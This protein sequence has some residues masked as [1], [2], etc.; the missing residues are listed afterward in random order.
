[1]WSRIRDLN[2]RSFVPSFA[3]WAVV[4]ALYL[5]AAVDCEAGDVLAVA[6]N[7]RH[8]QAVDAATGATLWREA[9]TAPPGWDCWF[10]RERLDGRVVFGHELDDPTAALGRWWEEVRDRDSGALVSA[11]E[12]TDGPLP[13]F[14]APEPFGRWVFGAWKTTI[15]KPEQGGC[16]N[17]WGLAAWCNDGSRIR[18]VPAFFKCLIY[19]WRFSPRLGSFH[20]TT[21]AQADNE[22]LG[23]WWINLVSPPGHEA[24]Q[25]LSP[26]ASDGIGGTF[27]P[28]L[29]VDE[30]ETPL[31]PTGFAW[32][33][34]GRWGW[35]AVIGDTMTQI[36]QWQDLGPAMIGY[37]LRES[38]RRGPDLVMAERTAGGFARAGAIDAAS[39]AVS[40]VSP[41]LPAAD[42]GGQALAQTTSFVVVAGPAQ[43]GDVPRLYVLDPASGAVARSIVLSGDPRFVSAVSSP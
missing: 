13:R 43:G 30:I 32:L 19:H 34:G 2:W 5:V 10:V 31:S 29:F 6:T 23:P 8:A 7:D 25:W 18:R 3:L 11:G 17:S 24:S 37:D 39:F 36:P 41:A 21:W 28:A 15:C 4:S 12:R 33:I 14:P 42:W 26:L 40:W 35:K 22:L 20:S 9:S 27:S 1:M 38:L 16:F